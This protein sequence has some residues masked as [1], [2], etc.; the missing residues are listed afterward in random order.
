MIDLE[1]IE[2][3]GQ[4]LVVEEFV[5]NDWSSTW[6]I[7]G[8]VRRRVGERWSWAAGAYWDQSPVPRRT[9]DPLLP[10]SDRLSATGG[11]TYDRGRFTLDVAG[12]WMRFDGQD[13]RGTSNPFP[14]EYQSSILGF[15]VTAGWRWGGRSETAHE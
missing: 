7:R 11:A 3:G 2:A 8:G 4:S 5:V 15:A 10:D 14:S 12:Q 1:P 6:A 9:A 13:T